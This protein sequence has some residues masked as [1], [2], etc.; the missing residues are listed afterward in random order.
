MMDWYTDN[1][2]IFMVVLFILFL[3]GVVMYPAFAGL[4][5][6]FSLI[7]FGS[8]SMTWKGS[9]IK[10][11]GLVL[12]VILAIANIG[13][14]GMKFGIDFSGGT[15]IP[16]VMEHKVDK[17][18]K[19]ELV[20]T[21]KKRVSVLGLSEAKVRA[22][23]DTQVNVEIP[24]TDDETISSIEETL[25]HQ[26][27][28]MGIVDGKIAVTG[29]D[30]FSS[31][32]SPQP[33]AQLQRS[34]ADWGVS[35]SVD[36]EGAE[37]FASA[38]DGKADYP[39]YMFLDRPTDAAL[40]YTEEQMDGFMR[41]DSNSR[42]SL[43]ALDDALALDEGNDINVYI[44]EEMENVSPG[45]E[46][47]VALVSNSTPSQKV[48]MIEDLG[49]EV[50]ILEDEQMR[51]NFTRT[52]SGVLIVTQLE[53]AGLL[54]SPLLAPELTTGVPSYN[55]GITGSAPG[56]TR[57]EIAENARDEEKSIESIL[58]G[59]SLPVQI[60]LGSRT[61]LPPSLGSE[62]LRLSL[63]AIIVALITISIL[64]G[65]RYM[66]IV[67]TLPIVAISIAELVILLS[68]LGSF[69]IDLA[70]MAGIIAA[71]GVGV[72]AQ[73]VITDELLKRDGHSRE[74]KMDHAFGIIKTNVVVATASMIPLLFSGLVEVI[75]FAISTI[76]GSVLGYLL[77]RPAYASI[78]GK[79]I[80]RSE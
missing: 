3:G 17:D 59:G 9:H 18:T 45:S 19:N 58:K 68:I 42:E 80:G 76:M 57:Q 73:I 2:F 46:D 54:S 49:F 11:G 37:R 67:A 25:A 71:I 14:N 36:R 44:I 13:L 62:F 1:K 5:L 39:I 22:I 75:G 20:Q 16:I 48:E 47:T 24:S 35:F 21:I 78:V 30:I 60:S 6:I 70:A 52:E 4:L 27:V 7:V 31:S 15:R 23:G 26:G 72:D 65:L 69:T 32:I 63:I 41:E 51:I 34:G 74:D 43:N 53:A 56:E 77:T 40:F 28:Y 12:I 64:I 8:L 61:S 29:E 33:P 79:I 55:F 10:I 50:R 66:N 38:A